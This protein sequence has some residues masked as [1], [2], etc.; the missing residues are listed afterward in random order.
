MREKGKRGGGTENKSSVKEGLKSTRQKNEERVITFKN[1][2][3][4]TNG[5]QTEMEKKKMCT[6]R[7]NDCRSKVLKT[8]ETGLSNDK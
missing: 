5:M 3:R 8:N 4:K 6:K 1:I 7:N 2:N